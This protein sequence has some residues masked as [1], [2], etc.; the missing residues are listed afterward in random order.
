MRIFS[1]VAVVFAAAIL[2]QIRS[3]SAQADTAEQEEQ[4]IRAAADS[5]MRFEGIE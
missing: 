2:C 3:V 1:L 4:A 5:A